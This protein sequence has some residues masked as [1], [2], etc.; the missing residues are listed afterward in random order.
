MRSRIRTDYFGESYCNSC[1]SSWL[2]LFHLRDRFWLPEVWEQGDST[3]HSIQKC[4]VFRYYNINVAAW[5]WR[6][7]GAAGVSACGGST[8]RHLSFV[9]RGLRIDEVFVRSV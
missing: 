4:V 8:Y 6:R 9:A 2:Q 5:S 3:T 1:V 7:V